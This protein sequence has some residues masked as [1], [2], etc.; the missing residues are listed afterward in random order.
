MNTTIVPQRNKLWLDVIGAALLAALVIVLFLPV[1]ADGVTQG[2]DFLDHLRDA[3]LWAEAGVALNTALRPHFTFH[4]LVIA[5]HILLGLE[6]PAAGLVTTLAL[7]ALLAIALYIL[8]RPTLK[9]PPLAA[10]SLSAV[11]AVSLVMASPVTLFTWGSQNLY[12]GYITLH[13]PHNPTQIT[14]EP[15]ALLFYVG[16]VLAFLPDK[17]T[18][19][20]L[21]VTF[22]VGLLSTLSKPSYAICLLP[23]VGLFTVYRLYRREGIHWL[24]LLVGVCLPILLVLSWQYLFHR[25]S[26]GGFDFEPFKV[27]E[28][29]S[30]GLIGLAAKFVLSI[31]F[32]ALVALAYF[33]AVR[34][35]VPLVLAW[36]AFGIGAGYTYLL[37]EPRDWPS[38]N[39]LWSGQISLFILF[40]MSTLFFIR[41]NIPVRW[42]DRKFIVCGAAFALHVISGVYWY[43]IQATQGIYAG[44]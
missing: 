42:L 10:V 1:V 35:S 5:T 12:L 30:P 26:L 24:H 17:P 14:L 23:A 38:G 20:S 27:M 19:K 7:R 16:A 15:F 31:L 39:F 11:I 43:S 2:A 13:V 25:S 9:L 41:Q 4:L 6:Y 40:V 29:L 32:P 28:H 22:I 37:I 36:L 3:R 21:V 18:V 34:H 44:W 33:P 8:L